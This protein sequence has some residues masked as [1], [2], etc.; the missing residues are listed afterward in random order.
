MSG[1]FN[2]YFLQ[3]VN[4]VPNEV[5]EALQEV[6]DSFYLVNYGNH[7]DDINKVLTDTKSETSKDLADRIMETYRMHIDSVILQQGVTL[8]DPMHVELKVLVHILHAV[9]LLGTVPIHDLIEQTDIDNSE[10]NITVFCKIA[11]S[12]SGLNVEQ[13]MEC[14]GGVST[15]VDEHLIEDL[16]YHARPTINNDIAELRFKKSDLSKTGIVVDAIRRL[17]A[18]GYDIDSFMK[19]NGPAIIEESKSPA[20]LAKEICLAVLG[21]NLEDEML[22]HTAAHY[23]ELMAEESNDALKAIVIIKR[24]LAS[25]E[26]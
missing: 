6:E 23:A 12:V 4:L 22:V 21:S 13:I 3:I 17:P 16:D 19:A 11:A 18:F 7:V 1:K 15:F 9:C 24:S 20:I 2:S 26:E 25:S 5:T 14:I 8:I 10:D